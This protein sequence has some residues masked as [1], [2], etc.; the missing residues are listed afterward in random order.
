VGSAV[1][2][3]AQPRVPCFKLGIRMG[4]RHFP[5]RFAAAGRPGAYLRIIVEGEL[6]AGDPLR[7]LSRP[8][9]EVTNGTVERAYHAERALVPLLF[10]APELPEGWLSW[11]RRVH[12]AGVT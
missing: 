1:L 4:D 5:R 12:E 8:D 9:H 10:T 3:V 6:G 2:E 7:V 11:A